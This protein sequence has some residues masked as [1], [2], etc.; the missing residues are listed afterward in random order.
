[1]NFQLY[2]LIESLHTQSFNFIWKNPKFTPKQIIEGYGTDAAALFKNSSDIQTI[3]ATT[4]PA[5]Q[6]LSIPAGYTVTFNEDGSAI[7]TKA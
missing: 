4:N 1:M 2:K 7:V 3:L 6:P 5:Y